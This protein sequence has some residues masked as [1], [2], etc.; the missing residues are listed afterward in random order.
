LLCMIAAVLAL[1]T[2]VSLVYVRF[3]STRPTIPA[4]TPGPSTRI[5]APVLRAAQIQAA[6]GLISEP[7]LAGTV[8]DRTVTLEGV[9]ADELNMALIFRVS[10]ATTTPLAIGLWDECGPLVPSAPMNVATDGYQ[11]LELLEAPYVSAGGLAHLK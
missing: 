9:Y 4:A 2:V 3:Q 6:S 5:P 1:L 11:Y 7:N 8:G 10:P